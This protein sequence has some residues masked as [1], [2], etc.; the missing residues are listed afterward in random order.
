MKRKISSFL[1]GAISVLTGAVFAAFW[2]TGCSLLFLPVSKRLAAPIICPG[3]YQ[4]SIVVQEITQPEP[5]VTRFSSDLYCVKASGRPV[6]VR[7]F[8]VYFGLWAAESA[9]IVVGVI[10][11]LI[12]GNLVF[13]RR[14]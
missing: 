12:L 14:A 11:S 6:R 7:D 4:R 9:G 8:E 13:R 5:G 10:A 2:L 3:G 1:I